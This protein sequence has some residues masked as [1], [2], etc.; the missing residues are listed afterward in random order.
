MAFFEELEV[1]KD[2]KLLTVSIYKM[3]RENR[4]YGFRD[5]IQRASV[6]IMN[7]I[8]EGSESGSDLTN[9]RFLHIAKGSCAE[10]RSMLYLAL[11]LGYC[12]SEQQIELLSLTRKISAYINKLIA[13]VRSRQDIINPDKT[14]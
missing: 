1:W 5:Q 2:A 14:T 12:T 11:E 8:A 13:Y 3:M 7:N 10:V 9:V 6:S 4:D